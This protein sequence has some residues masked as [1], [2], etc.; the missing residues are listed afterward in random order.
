MYAAFPPGEEE[1]K[2]MTEFTQFKRT[3]QITIIRHR[4]QVDPQGKWF[5]S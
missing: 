5:N 4:Q 3:K 1:W 2:K